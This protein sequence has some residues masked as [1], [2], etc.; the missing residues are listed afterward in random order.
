[1]DGI[2]CLGTIRK[3]R[4]PGLQFPNDKIMKKQG[5]GTFEEYTTTVQGVPI[6]A[7]KWF[8]NKSVCLASTFCG[9]QPIDIVQRFDRKTKTRIGV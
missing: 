5:R 2:Y 1:M 8:D 7:L 6:I 9:S 4:I 3:D